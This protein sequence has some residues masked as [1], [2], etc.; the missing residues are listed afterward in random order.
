MCERVSVRARA[1]VAITAA[2]RPLVAPAADSREL[3]DCARGG[4][5][6]VRGGQGLAHGGGGGGEGSVVEAWRGGG[7]GGGRDLWNRSICCLHR[8]WCRPDEA[9]RGGRRC[10]TP[11]N[12]Y[13]LCVCVCL[14]RVRETLLE[15]V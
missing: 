7:G 15:V 5:G 11:L 10:P 4:Q 8:R 3:I 14:T 12:P 9:K 1:T 2:R 13:P 6:S